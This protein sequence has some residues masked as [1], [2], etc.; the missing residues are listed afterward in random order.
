M[1]Y[2]AIAVQVNGGCNHSW[3]SKA[4]L[5]IVSDR[6]QAAV[7]ELNLLWPVTTRV[8][9]E[10]LKIILSREGYLWLIDVIVTLGPQ[11]F[12]E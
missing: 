7:V 10:E 2:V 6:L 5:N 11:I 1:V 9:E 4:V 12:I 3:W 8:D